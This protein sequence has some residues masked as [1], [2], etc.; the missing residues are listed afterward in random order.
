MMEEE[1]GRGGGGRN[2]TIQTK[3]RRKNQR[4]DVLAQSMNRMKK[5]VMKSRKKKG[6]TRTIN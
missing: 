5:L 4:K 6:N 1:G 2:E 3:H